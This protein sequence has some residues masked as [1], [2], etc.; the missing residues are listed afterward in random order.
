M[1]NSA[2]VYSD[3]IPKQAPFCFQQPAKPIIS[4]TPI[5]LGYSSRIKVEWQPD[6]T[7]HTLSYN[8][9]RKDISAGETDFSEIYSGLPAD[10]TQ[11]LNFVD[12]AK[13]Y[14]YEVEAIGS[15]ENSVFSDPSNEA[16]GLECSK[17][18]PFPPT[19]FLNLVY[20]MDH[21]VAV[22]IGWTDVGNAD[23]YKVYRASSPFVWIATNPPNALN[24]VDYDVTDDA[25]YQYQVAAS[26]RNGDTLSNILTVVVPIA[27]PGD[28]ILSGSWMSG[29]AKIYL[30]WT[31]ALT[32]EAG[33][34]VT[35]RVL[36]AGSLTFDSSTVVCQNISS[37]PLICYDNS[38]SSSEKFYKV[39]ATNNGGITDSNILQMTSPL[40]FWKEVAP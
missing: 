18:P 30:T 29:G 26:N 2:S 11:N 12:E 6:L 5:C 15:G 38:P 36:R 23:E 4:V 19:L 35:Y 22:S 24:Y 34:A 8:I 33:G 28:F 39:E 3:S 20:S 31:E 25:T 7:G 10:T 40:P 9:W 32:S 16:V 13:T 21:H 14:V 37:P 1:G 17:I 27:R